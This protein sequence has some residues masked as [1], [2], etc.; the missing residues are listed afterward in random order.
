[1]PLIA[2]QCIGLIR[3]EESGIKLFSQQQGIISETDSAAIITR[4]WTLIVPAVK[5]P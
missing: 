1:M 3:S 2:N 4:E 5:T